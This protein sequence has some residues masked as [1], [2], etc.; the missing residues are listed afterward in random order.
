MERVAGGEEIL[1]THRGKP[2]VRLSP[3]T[4]PGPEASP[5]IEPF[6][7]RPAWPPRAPP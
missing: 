1:I 3:A 2:R 5:P 6:N 7:P 4:E